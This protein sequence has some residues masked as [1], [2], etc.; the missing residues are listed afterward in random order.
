MR[1]CERGG[2]DGETLSWP[3]LKKNEM[4]SDNLQI[5]VNKNIDEYKDDFFKGLTLKQTVTSVVALVFGAG[6]FLGL[7]MLFGISQTTALYLTF[8]V[9]FP[10]AAIGFLKIDVMTPVT[11]LKRRRAV[12]N[13]P[14]YFFHPDMQDIKDEKTEIEE[15][16]SFSKRKGNK[17]NKMNYLIAG[18]E[19]DQEWQ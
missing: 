15:M 4:G 8:P 18:G 19:G 10:I 11:W 3:W 9:V 16:S 14:V 2:D 17:R 12:R 7:T 1:L 5:P 13:M 6:M